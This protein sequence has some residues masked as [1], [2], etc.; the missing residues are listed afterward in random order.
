L[1]K[2]FHGCFGFSSLAAAV[3][4]AIEEREGFKR[5]KIS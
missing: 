2:Y 1:Q 5:A 4:K 3:G